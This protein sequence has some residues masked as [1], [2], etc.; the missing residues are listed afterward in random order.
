MTQLFHRWMLAPSRR[1]RL[2]VVATA[3]HLKNEEDT[4]SRRSSPIEP[5]DPI[6]R[7]WLFLQ[8]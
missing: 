6:K 5:L 8:A 1:T 2:S 4:K 3:Q 7:L